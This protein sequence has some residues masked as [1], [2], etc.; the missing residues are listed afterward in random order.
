MENA[1]EAHVEIEGINYYTLLE[2]P[3]S[4][5]TTTTNNPP[6]VVLLVHALMSNHHMWDATVRTLTTAGYTTLRYDHAGHHHTP[7]PH[8]PNRTYTLDDLTRHAHQLVKTRT[9]SPNLHAVIGCSIGGVIALRYAT[10]FPKDLTRIISIAAPGLDPPPNAKTLWTDR[11]KQFQQD[12]DSGTDTLAHAT[13]A[14]WI[15]GDDPLDPPIR[16]QALAH[17]K[18]CTLAGYRVLADAITSY[19][20]ESEAAMFPREVKCLIVA[21]AEDAAAPVERLRDVAGRIEGAG[22]VVM[23]AGHLPPMQREGEFGEVAVEFLR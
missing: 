5:I 2:T 15:P 23:E 8:D 10:L 22:F 11:I 18:T 14:R 20:Y 6:P 19:A 13:I 4:T 3:P 16:A 9:N 12:L 17:V 7:P 21:G 1:S